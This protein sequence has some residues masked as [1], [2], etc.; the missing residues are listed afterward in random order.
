MLNKFKKLRTEHVVEQIDKGRC[1]Y[2]QNVH[3]KKHNN[4]I[5]KELFSIALKYCNRHGLEF[6]HW[7]FKQFALFFVSK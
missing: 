4:I 7:F 2:I 6:P 1:F 5:R 3:R